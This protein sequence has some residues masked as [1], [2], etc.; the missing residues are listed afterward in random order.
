M[1]K[2]FISLG[3]SAD[4]K[5][6]HRAGGKLSFPL[7]G[8]EANEVIDGIEDYLEEAECMPL[9]D[10]QSQIL[11]DCLTHYDDRMLRT[12]FFEWVPEPRN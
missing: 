3:I 1:E 9:S 12:H 4:G 11:W 6:I 7:S 5:T 8:P 10:E 2:Q